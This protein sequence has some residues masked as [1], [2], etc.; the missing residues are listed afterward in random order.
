[1]VKRKKLECGIPIH[2]PASIS[3]TYK[4]K[5]QLG[6]DFY[7]WVNKEWLKQTE[8]PAF[9]P[10]F[11]VSEEVEQC[12][13]NVSEKILA[14]VEDSSYR[15]F[16]KE[17]RESCLTSSYQKESVQYLKTILSNVHCI[18]DVN[19]VVEHMAIFAKTMFASF[20]NL[21]YYIDPD[22]TLHL[23]LNGNS[24]GIHYSNYENASKMKSYKDMLRHLGDLL[25]FPNIDK[26]FHLEKMLVYNSENLWDE[27]KLKLR[28]SQF[29]NKFPGF[30]WELWFETLGIKEW[31][32]TVFY[33]NSPRWIRFF[34][35]TLNSVPIEYW[36]LY[37]ARC[38]ILN[39]I[40]YLPA[41]F[42]QI[43]YEFFG[44]GLGG[45]K[46]KMPQN[47][48]FVN[49]VYEYLADEYSKLLWERAGD[50]KLVPEINEFTKSLVEAAKRRIEGT[51]WLEYKTRRLAIQKVDHMT[52]STVRPA[53]WAPTLDIP[54]DPK[55]LLK[56]IFLLGE[57][58]VRKMYTRIGHPY[59]FWEEGIFN[60][61]AYYY[62]EN[63]EIMI[64]Y[65]TCISPF[66]SRSMPIAWNYGGLGAIIGHEICHG[67]DEDG[68]EYDQ[69]G[70]KKR[71]WTR[72]DRQ[73]YKNRI[74]DL[75]KLY[76]KQIIEH[77]HV[78]GEKTA[79][80]NIADLGGLSISL[81]ALK[82]SLQAAGIVDP[83]KVKEEL[84]M[85]F[86]SFATSWRTK[87]RN[88][89]LK[90]ALKTDVH[91]PANLRVNLIV[92]QFDEWYSCFDI[93]EDAKLYISP[94]DRI[95]IF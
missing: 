58:N 21:E 85:F 84:K 82:D 69:G 78:N 63:N 93:Q 32:S 57:R 23:F 67:F 81:Q 22:K 42:D 25:E 41:P 74:K 31:K 86:I 27:E 39:S 66:Y 24:P 35:K 3:F 76:S 11:G 15:S 33:Y 56:N 2:L 75:V 61:N 16:F 12:I 17:L 50:E 4:Q 40:K 19:G 30:P 29:V 77:Q 26:I 83:E 64:P 79:S 70:Y 87:I 88:K 60:V 6:N 34:I 53:H 51:E 65:G 46:E 13:F 54:L 5:S 94:K 28:G 48:L 18:H 55:N 73:A 14:D 43:D 90:T 8:I 45:Q 92:A 47:Y 10:D 49:I 72:G 68:K 62:N 38:Y 80:E 20:L 44:K 9:R 7:T 91:A 36:K 59:K 71:W 89:R 95:R 37:I 52:L 1:M